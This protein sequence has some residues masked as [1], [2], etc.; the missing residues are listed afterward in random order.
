MIGTDTVSPFPARRGSGSGFVEEITDFDILGAGVLTSGYCDVEIFVLS[1][2]VGFL[3]KDFSG[4][5]DFGG[6]VSR[7]IPMEFSW[8]P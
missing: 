5:T 2:K 3:R 1:G 6:C 8:V 7:R 4:E